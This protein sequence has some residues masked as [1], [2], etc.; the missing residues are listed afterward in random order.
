MSDKISMKEYSEVFYEF[1]E[2]ITQGVIIPYIPNL[3]LQNKG[4]LALLVIENA[5]NLVEDEV[6]KPKVERVEYIFLY[7]VFTY[8]EIKEKRI[9]VQT[10]QFIIQNRRFD[11]EL[12]YLPPH[13]SIKKCQECNLITILEDSDECIYCS[14]ETQNLDYGFLGICDYSGYIPLE[15]LK[16]L[17]FKK[18]LC[19][20]TPYRDYINNKYTQFKLPIAI[21][22]ITD[23]EAIKWIITNVLKD[24]GKKTLTEIQQRFKISN[25]GQKIEDLLEQGYLKYNK[26]TGLYTYSK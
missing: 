19:V 16:K 20:K 23:D 1:K 18:Y 10:F 8:L 4:Q 17:K 5:C 13:D 24:E 21:K 7:D 11:T 2:Y 6:R 14:K 9:D 25:I 22:T 15:L 3:Q 26:K 12:V